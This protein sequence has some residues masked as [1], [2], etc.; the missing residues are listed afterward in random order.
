MKKCTDYLKIAAYGALCF[1]FLSFSTE[2]PLE[3]ELAGLQQQLA[4]HYNAETSGKISG[5]YELRLTGSGFCRY[6]RFYRDG[7]TEYFSFNL[8]KLKDL[9]YYGSNRS[10]LL[11]LRTGSD[12]VIVQTYNRRRGEDVDS[13]ARCMS[14][15]V[16]N[17]EAEQLNTLALQFQ[18]L[19]LRFR[20]P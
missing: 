9:D 13:M 18:Q 15:P 8:S 4:D 2:D 19:S 16:K 3:A 5:K 11:V 7:M 12:D 6:K 1:F 17:I 10:G 14:I 20:K